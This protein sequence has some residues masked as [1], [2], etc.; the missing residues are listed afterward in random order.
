MNRYVA[1][2]SYISDKGK[3][4]HCVILDLKTSKNFLLFMTLVT[5]NHTLGAK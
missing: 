3:G 2:D 4:F 5:K 1:S